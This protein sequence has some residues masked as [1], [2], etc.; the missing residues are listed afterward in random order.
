[1][2]KIIE[3]ELVII[4]DLITLNEDVTQKLILC[5]QIQIYNRGSASPY[6]FTE[7]IQDVDSYSTVSVK[8]Q[9]AN[10]NNNQMEISYALLELIT[11]V[12]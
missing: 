3:I 9:P 10:K 12:K 2:I 8:Y 7:T 1:M 11:Q 5:A 6:F 4:I